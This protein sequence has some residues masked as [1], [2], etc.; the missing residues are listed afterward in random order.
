MQVVFWYF[1]YCALYSVLI[2]DLVLCSNWNVLPVSQLKFNFGEKCGIKIS[3][4]YTYKPKSN[5]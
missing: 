1:L 5:F 2:V 4:T 3:H